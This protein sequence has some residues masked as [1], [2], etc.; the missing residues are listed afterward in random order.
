MPDFRTS[1]TPTISDGV[2][3]R[4]IVTGSEVKILT[5]RVQS[6]TSSKI[7]HVEGGVVHAYLMSGQGLVLTKG[8]AEAAGKRQWTVLEQAQAVSFYEGERFAFATNEEEAH[9]II[10]YTGNVVVE[11][12]LQAALSEEEMSAA[13]R[14][15]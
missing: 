4:S 9:M 10:F 3:Y 14:I 11:G 13:K 6:G 2:F 8:L 15:G 1:S 5:M 7:R 12:P